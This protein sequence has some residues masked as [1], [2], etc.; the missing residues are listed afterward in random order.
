MKNLPGGRQT[1]R[2]ACWM[3]CSTAWNWP[4]TV[5]RAVLIRTIIRRVAGMT[6]DQRAAPLDQLEKASPIATAERV[7]VAGSGSFSPSID[8]PLQADA[9]AEFYIS[10]RFRR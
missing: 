7:A 1:P 9:L 10:Q 8:R 5:V 4:L 2:A 3:R 6:A